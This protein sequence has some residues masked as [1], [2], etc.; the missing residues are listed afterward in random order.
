[1]TVLTLFA[2]RRR[3]AG[4]PIPGPVP[5]VLAALLAA[6]L[7]AMPARCGADAPVPTLLPQRPALP[8]VPAPAAP[9]AAAARPRMRR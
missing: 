9:R 2:P 4:L 1:M 6:G 5:G 8:A 7:S 3:A